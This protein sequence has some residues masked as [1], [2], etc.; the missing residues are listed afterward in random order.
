M[1]K[2]F[3]QMADLIAHNVACGAAFAGAFVIVEPDGTPHH[4]LMLDNAQNPARFWATLQTRC[5]IAL[6]ELDGKSRRGTFG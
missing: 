6:D 2:P 5:K 4:L 1:N 3:T